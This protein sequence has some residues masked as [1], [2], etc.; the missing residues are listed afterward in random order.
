MNLL[1]EH[2]LPE[3]TVVVPTMNEGSKL[4]GALNA[5]MRQTRQDRITQLIIV[6]GGS[7]DNTVD[8]AESVGAEVIVEQKPGIEHAR[9]TGWKHSRNNIVLNTDADTRL[10]PNWLE[11]GLAHFRDPEV[12][13]VAGPVIPL[14]D[15][16]G[17]PWYQLAS[18]LPNAMNQGWNTILFRKDAVHAKK[19]FTEFEDVE[20]WGELRRNGKVMWDKNLLSHTE[21]PTTGDK[22]AIKVIAAVGVATF[23]YWLYKTRG[24]QIGQW[25]L[26]HWEGRYK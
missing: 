19:W 6:D 16:K 13:G 9:R 18:G 5:L 4:T 22:L 12:S 17:N 8:I 7:K 21:F 26:D 14:E 23:F 10:Q 24:S 2:E 1:L 20:L 3:V 15:Q 11:H 25:W